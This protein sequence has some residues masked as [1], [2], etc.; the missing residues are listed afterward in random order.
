MPR[1]SMPSMLPMSPMPLG[2]WVVQWVAQ[3]AGREQPVVQIR[4]VQLQLQVQL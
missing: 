2:A 4:Q 1:P 3:R